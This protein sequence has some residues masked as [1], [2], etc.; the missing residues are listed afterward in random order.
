MRGDKM[1]RIT[2]MTTGDTKKLILSFAFPLIITN[3]GQQ[4]Y[5]LID[6]AIIGRGVGVSALAAVG[7]TVWIY[8]IISWSILSLT[9]G[10]STFISRY[11]GMDDKEM[12]NRYF[13]MSAVLSF[14]ISFVFTVIGIAASKPLLVL[15]DTPPEILEDALT[16]LYVMIGGTFAVMG[17]NLTSSVLRAFGDGKSPLI[18]MIIAAILNVALDLLFVVVIP[19]GVF[20]AAFAS[21]IAQFVSF[22]YCIFE[23][24]KIPYIEW[25]K[26]YY[27]W[28]GAL[29]S[30]LLKFSLPLATQNAVLSVGGLVLQSAV[31]LEGSVFIAGYTATNRLYGMFECTAI[32]LGHSITTFMSQNYG[33]GNIERVKKGFNVSFVICVFFSVVVSVVMIIL[34]KFL[35][36]LF[37]D[38]SEPGAAESLNIAFRYLLVMLCSLVILYLLYLYRST[39][40]AIGNSTWS[41]LSGFGECFVRILFAKV[42][43]LISGREVI[44]FVETGAWIGAL[45]FVIFPCY[46]YIK[47]MAKENS[48]VVH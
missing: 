40:Q 32:A 46:H 36:G 15:L 43:Y 19:W 7:C 1:T 23:I 8:G 13:G 14:I 42:L 37:I 41:M 9:Y 30:N 12:I 5:F 47:R 20:G 38:P 39:L 44:Y 22:I 34:G 21:V 33:I 48:N 35:L 10:F 11:F 16:Y 29:A 27:K 25:K 17:Y 4:L 26:D 3:I 24:K 6:T 31:N 18:A 2:N 45:V 28:D